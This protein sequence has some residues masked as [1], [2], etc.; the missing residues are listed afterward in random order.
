[1][2]G[3]PSTVIA[4]VVAPVKQRKL[5]EQRGAFLARFCPAVLDGNPSE[6]QSRFKADTRHSGRRSGIPSRVEYDT[7]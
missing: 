7:T 5:P 1:M 2:A 3:K 4:R 6:I